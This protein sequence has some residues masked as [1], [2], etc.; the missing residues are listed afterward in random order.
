MGDYNDNGYNDLAIANNGDNLITLFEGGTDGLVL[1]SSESLNPSERP[2]DLVFSGAESGQLHLDISAAGEDQVIPV[3]LTVGSSP[4]STVPDGGNPSNQGSVLEA[5]ASRGSPLSTTGLLSFDLQTS[6]VGSQLQ[7]T[8]PAATT[9]GGPTGVSGQ[10]AVGMA[11][12]LTTL[13][14]MIN[15]SSGSL[16]TVINNLG[17]VAQVQ[18]SDLMALDNSA[19]EAVAVLLVVSSESVESSWGRDIPSPEES[20]PGVSSAVELARSRARDSCASDSN[21]ERFLSDLEGALDEVPRDVLAVTEQ[22]TGAW[23]EWV[24]R[25]REPGMVAVTVAGAAQQDRSAAIVNPGP[26]ASTAPKGHASTDFALSDLRRFD[27]LSAQPMPTTKAAS[28]GLG[29]LVPF[30]G[31]LVISSVVLGWKAARKQWRAARSSP[32]PEIAGPHS[33]SRLTMSASK[34]S[35]S[36]LPNNDDLPPWL[37][38]S[39]AGRSHRRLAR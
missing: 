21:L 39:I 34:S 19:M 16:P 11:T 1:T 29:W 13:D 8:T 36:R 10:V 20:A 6:E 28:F 5:A 26:A 22:Q 18:I 32:S 33:T 23:P 31:I 35:R 30:C 7:G 14:Q 27:W 4:S 37:A 25:P 15:V 2:T 24:L 38:A 17:Q 9:S 3:T 12:I